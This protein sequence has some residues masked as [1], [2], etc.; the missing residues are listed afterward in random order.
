M[1][2]E[3]KDLN[4]EPIKCNADEFLFI[5]YKGE[6]ADDLLDTAKNIVEY[7]GENDIPC[8]V[9]PANDEEFYLELEQMDVT[10][11]RRLDERIQA[12]IQKKSKIILE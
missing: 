12:E 4:L 3:L 6:L 8:L 1:Q 7:C 9:I 11:L 5:R 2:M 10:A